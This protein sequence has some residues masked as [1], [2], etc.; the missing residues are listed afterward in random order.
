VFHIV[1]DEFKKEEFLLPISGFFLTPASRPLYSEFGS[2]RKY[3]P[4]TEQT[5]G[6]Q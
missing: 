6:R 5:L 1:H 3:S 4:K 2:K